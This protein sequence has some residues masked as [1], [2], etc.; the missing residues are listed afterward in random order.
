M[1]IPEFPNILHR[2]ANPEYLAL[3][4]RKLREYEGRLHLYAGMGQWT[5]DALKIRVLKKLLEDGQ[6]DRQAFA[7]ELSRVHGFKQTDFDKACFLIHDYA[8]TGGQ[9]LKT[10]DV[11]PTRQ[12][13]GGGGEA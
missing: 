13:V 11:E 7:A 10:F 3:L 4:K 8:T 6:V 12:F 9:R 5:E 2:P 1:P